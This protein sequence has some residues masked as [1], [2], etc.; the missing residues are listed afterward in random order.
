MIKC[1]TKEVKI[2]GTKMDE[3]K[4]LLMHRLIWLSL[5]IFVILLPIII[6]VF[7][8]KLELLDSE[9]YV[10]YYESID[11]TS[12]DITLYFNREV[13]SGYATINFYD[14]NNN[15]IDS[16][17]K[18]FYSYGKEASNSYISIDGNVDS[19][20][21]VSYNLEPYN[22]IYGMYIL[23]F[24]TV[25]MLI[26]AL[27]LTYKKYNYNG[28]TISVYAGFYH[29]T[30]RIDGELCDEHNTIMSFTPIMLSTTD[31]EGNKIEANISLTN[32]IAI[33]VNDK[34]LK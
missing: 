13:N 16:L 1:N 9:C 20:E 24:I 22:D 29:H 25:P 15:L 32:R 31:S 10:D 4:K 5:T 11:T 26:C 2:K 3:K 23:L 12:C 19:Y 27:L 21:I 17:E 8:P 28:K 30:L 7:Q 34:L 14:S 18:Y 33:K 6:S